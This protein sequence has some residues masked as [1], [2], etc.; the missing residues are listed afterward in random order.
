MELS[1]LREKLHSL[2]DSSTE[3]RLLEV[4]DLFEQDY[5][6]EFK[7]QLEEE[8]TGYKKNNEV[9]SR[10]ETDRM[11]NEILHGKRNA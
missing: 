1:S 8:Y 6:D 9:I 4:N 3:S 7:M 11:V 5:T 10:Q 2:I